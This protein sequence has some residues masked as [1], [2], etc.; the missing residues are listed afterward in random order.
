MFEDRVLGF[1]QYFDQHV[2]VQ[3]LKGAY[4]RKAPYKLGDH[5]ELAKI[6]V[7][8]IFQNIL[9]IVVFVPDLGCESDGGLFGQSLPDNA[10][11]IREG[12]A[13]DEQDIPGVDSRQGDHCILAVGSHG[14][15]YIG[16]FK[17]LE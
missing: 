7:G 2:R 9:L 5:S 8:H 15:L 1:F 14:D 4:D 3:S 11:K 16:A 13:A 17:E 10:L 6:L 12:S